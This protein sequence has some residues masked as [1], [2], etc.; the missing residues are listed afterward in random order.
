MQLCLTKL[1]VIFEIDPYVISLDFFF[2]NER[3]ISAT[4][5][6][7]GMSANTDRRITE[8]RNSQNLC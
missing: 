7:K 5:N 2:F 6:F 4:L 3:I 1:S 8:R